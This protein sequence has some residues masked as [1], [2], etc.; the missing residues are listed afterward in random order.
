MNTKCKNN[1]SSLQVASV[2]LVLASLFIY[3]F[4]IHSIYI[5]VFVVLLEILIL[6]YI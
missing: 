1:D 2:G 5:V 6:K 4:F 3:L